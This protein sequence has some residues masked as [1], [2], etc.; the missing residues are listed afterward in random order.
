MLYYEPLM[1][2]SPERKY[3]MTTISA[4]GNCLCAKDI[5]HPRVSLPL[6]EHGKE[7]INKMMSNYPALPVVNDKLQVIGIVSEYDILDALE[8]GRTINEFSAESI[9]TC[10]HTG[11]T[12]VCGTP[13]FVTPDT[14]IDAVVDLFYKEHFSILPVVESCESKK[15]V[16][17]ISRKNI[18]NALG[19]EGFWPEHEFQKR[20]KAA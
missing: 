2:Q 17:L 8:E 11:H 9:M 14:S 19:E 7:L 12:D 5:M 15:L 3:V 10:G 6:K 18:I 13:L 16:G 4:K 1:G 20:V